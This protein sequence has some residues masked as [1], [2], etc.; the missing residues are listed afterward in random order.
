[1]PPDPTRRLT[2][3]APGSPPRPAAPAPA[4]GV[5]S[6]RRGWRWRRRAAIVGG[7]LATGLLAAWAWS[8]LHPAALAAAEASYRRHDLKAALRLCEAHLARRPSSRSAARLAAR[9]L[10]QLGRPDQAEAYYE[11][12]APLELEDRHIRAL[13]LVVNNRREP[14]IRA[15]REILKRRPDDVLAL[16]RMAAVLISESRW[17]DTLRT[18][19][20][21]IRI[22]E[23]AVIGHTLAGVVHHNTRD[24]ELAVFAFDR[25]VELDPG[26]KR[27]PLKPRSMFWTEYGH[28]LLAV[29]R[30]A[31]ARRCLHRA[32]EEGDDAK[33]ADLLG[34]SYYL[35]GALDDAEQWWRVALQW[36]PDRFGTWWRLGKLELQRGRPAEAIEPLRRAA[37]LEPKAVGP[38]YSLSL[39]Y[40][41]LGRGAESDR[42]LERVARLR[43]AP[44]APNRGAADRSLLETGEIAR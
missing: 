28:N 1:M 10:S 30:W 34:Q 16:S 8:E 7:L 43:G 24:S 15:Y 20:R 3:E 5:E 9:C 2:L 6:P 36:D 41:R 35:E 40:R 25:V 32:L 31:D 14:A 27:M 21:L 13:A 18:A 44:G 17:E 39:V 29:G 22:P 19:D 12:A 38:L 33:V 26:L 4:R 37:V 23:G 42:L 11:K